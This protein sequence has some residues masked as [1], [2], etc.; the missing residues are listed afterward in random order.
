LVAS[1]G[2]NTYELP[3]NGH[4]K[5]GPILLHGVLTLEEEPT[6]TWWHV[7]GWGK[8]S[9]FV[10]GFNLGRYWSIGPQ[11]T[12]YIPKEHLKKGD[13]SIVVLELQKV[14]LDLDFNFS[15]V[16]DFNEN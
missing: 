11:M 13:N 7:K 1:E 15:D 10:N 2:D 5:E 4:L 6:D 12:Q 8:G 16:A 14:P 9:L 3:R